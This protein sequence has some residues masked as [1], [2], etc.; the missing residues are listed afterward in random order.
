[1]KNTI[2][3]KVVAVVAV[4][5]VRAAGYGPEA[6]RLSGVGSLC[7]EFSASIPSSLPRFV[8]APPRYVEANL[9][10]NSRQVGLRAIARRT[11]QADHYF[12]SSR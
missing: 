4:A 9:P 12:P 1:M 10:G 7:V 6:N 11:H 2:L 5:L 3:G 8:V